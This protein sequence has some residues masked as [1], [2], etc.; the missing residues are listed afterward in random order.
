MNIYEKASFSQK[1]SHQN[2]GQN[3]QVEKFTAFTATIS[4]D[5]YKKNIVFTK[6]FAPK[7]RSEWSGRE[8]HSSHGDY[9]REHFCVRVS[10]QL[11]GSFSCW[12]GWLPVCPDRPKIS[13]PGCIYL[14]G[15]PDRVAR[16]L[17][18]NRPQCPKNVVVKKN[19]R[20][21]IPVRMVRSRVPQLPRGQFS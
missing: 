2:S 10:R 9:F 11:S 4:V 7:F 16:I 18:G 1:R 15:C 19:V 13:L 14:P 3:G 6:T 20:T 17:P 5:I 12:V 8:V 21:E